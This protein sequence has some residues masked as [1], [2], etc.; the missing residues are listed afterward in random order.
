MI[1]RSTVRQA[2]TVS[3]QPRIGDLRKDLGYGN[4]PGRVARRKHHLATL[5]ERF[6]I[7][8]DCPSLIAPLPPPLAIMRTDESALAIGSRSSTM[9]RNEA[10]WLMPNGLPKTRSICAGASGA[11]EK[12]LIDGSSASACGETS[13]RLGHA[14]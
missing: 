8:P 7:R 10:R 4:V 6:N 9:K 12:V 2:S 3:L 11:L 13:A 1:E 14:W 5:V